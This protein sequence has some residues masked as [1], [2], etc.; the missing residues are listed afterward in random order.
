MSFQTEKTQRLNQ[1]SLVLMVNPYAITIHP[2]P[3]METICDIPNVPLKGPES[4]R[5]SPLNPVS[6]SSLEEKQTTLTIHRMATKLPSPKC[7]CRLM[8][9]SHTLISS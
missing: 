4:S 1:S 8:Y 6:T 2:K 9:L 7:R 3:V 5:I